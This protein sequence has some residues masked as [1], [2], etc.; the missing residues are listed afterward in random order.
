MERPVEDAFEVSEIRDVQM[1]MEEFATKSLSEFVGAVA[2]FRSR[3][4]DAVAGKSEILL[5]QYKFQIFKLSGTGSGGVLP[6]ESK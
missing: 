1:I 3:Y 4:S 2:S 5:R 6:Y